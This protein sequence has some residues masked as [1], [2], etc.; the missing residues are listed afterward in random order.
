MKPKGRNYTN[1]VRDRTVYTHT[2]IKARATPMAEVSTLWATPP[3]QGLG[4]W[5]T[6]EAELEPKVLGAGP[7]RNSV[8]GRED[9]ASRQ[10]S[11]GRSRLGYLHEAGY[12]ATVK[13][14]Q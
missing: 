4:T 9:Q 7:T 6:K 11:R 2:P 3:N 14:T 13:G 8:R 10:S 12:S 5:N 1:Y